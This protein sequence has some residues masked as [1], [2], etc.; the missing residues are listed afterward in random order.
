MEDKNIPEVSRAQRNE[1]L[2]EIKKILSDPVQRY[3]KNPVPDL[4]DD[5][6]MP[7]GIHTGK[8]MK[9]I[10]RQYFEWYVKDIFKTGKGLYSGNIRDQIRIYGQNKYNIR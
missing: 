10:P 4:S 8:C 3:Y 6:I 7:I 5:S 9:D 2:R 1:E